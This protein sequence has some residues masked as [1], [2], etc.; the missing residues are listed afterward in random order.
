MLQKIVLTAIFLI[1][2][3]S[4]ANAEQLKISITSPRNRA[5]V[6]E[7]QVI[8]GK[9]TDPDAEVWVI[10]HPMVKNLD[11]RWVQ[12]KVTVNESGDWKVRAY[13]GE[14]GDKGKRFEIMAIANPDDELEEGNILYNWPNAEAKSRI[15]KVRRK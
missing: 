9:V 5:S 6:S 1:V 14:S 11:D 4:I 12:P 15:I 2:T 8:K 7:K 10:I 3:A 13:I